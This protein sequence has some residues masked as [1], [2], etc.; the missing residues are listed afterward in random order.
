MNYKLMTLTCPQWKKFYQSLIFNNYLTK[1]YIIESSESGFLTQKYT[2][3]L[4][5][6]YELQID[7]VFHGAKK[8]YQYSIFSNYIAKNTKHRL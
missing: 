4:E 6:I 7:D 2:S 3:P 1:M 8:F 5:T